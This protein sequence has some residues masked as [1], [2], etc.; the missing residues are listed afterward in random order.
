MDRS[1]DVVQIHLVADL[2]PEADT[3]DARLDPGQPHEVLTRCVNY[4]SIPSKRLK[5]RVHL[6]R[7]AALG[8]E[9]LDYALLRRGSERRCR[10]E[11]VAFLDDRNPILLGIR[12]QAIDYLACDVALK[13]E[14]G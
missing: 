11:R 2:A 5:V 3:F 12:D 8:K 7:S 6:R 4:L 13:V 9:A 1:D 14:V 10:S